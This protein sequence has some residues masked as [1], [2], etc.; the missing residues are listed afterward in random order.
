MTVSTDL[1][2]FKRQKGGY[3]VTITILPVY[4]CCSILNSKS[5]KIYLLTAMKYTWCAYLSPP[6]TGINYYNL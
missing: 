4:L 5:G 3:K 6:P 1:Q 2:A